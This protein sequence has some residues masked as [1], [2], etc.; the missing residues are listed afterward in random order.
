MSRTFWIFLLGGFV[1][2]VAVISLEFAIVDAVF[3]VNPH[4]TNLVEVMFLAP[5]FFSVYGLLFV[6][7]VLLLGAGLATLGRAA[8]GHLPIWLLIFILPIC[9]L[10]ELWWKMRLDFF[11]GEM[12][13]LSQIVLPII[14]YQVPVLLGYWWWARRRI[15]N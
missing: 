14:A 1:I 8:L 6:L 5:L 13:P 15:S 2:A 4:H 12:A 10:F 11:E 9:V 3:Y 7:P